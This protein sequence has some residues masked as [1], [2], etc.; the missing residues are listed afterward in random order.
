MHIYY[1][2]SDARVS[3]AWTT[4]ILDHSNGFTK[5]ESNGLM[6]HKDLLLDHSGLTN[7]HI[8]GTGTAFD[9]QK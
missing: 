3:N 7:I 1:I 5:A 2:A 8:L 4:F 9:A 6:K